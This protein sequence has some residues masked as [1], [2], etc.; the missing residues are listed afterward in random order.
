MGW[1]D[2]RQTIL[3]ACTVCDESEERAVD[4]DIVLPDYYAPIA[5]IVKCTLHPVVT[6]CGNVGGRYTVD[7]IAKLRMLYVSDDRQHLYCYE[8]NHPFSVAFCADDAVHHDIDIYVDY[9]NCRASAPRRADVHAAFRVHMKAVGTYG[10]EMFAPPQVHDVFCRTTTLERSIP[11][12]EIYKSFSVEDAIELGVNVD[13]MIYTDIEMSSYECKPLLNKAI[14]KGVLSVRSMC[15]INDHN[16]I[17][18]QEIPFSQIIDVN[19]LC[20]DWQCEICV[21]VGEN[22]CHLQQGETGGA[23]L[24]INARL[25]ACARCTAVLTDEIVLDAYAVKEAVVCELTPLHTITMTPHTPVKV[26]C[27]QQTNAPENTADIL[28]VKGVV[29]TKDIV[30]KNGGNTLLC[31]V[32]VSMIVRDRDGVLHHCERTVDL[33]C[34]LEMLC[35]DATVRCVRVSPTLN[36]EQVRLQLELLITPRMQSETV[37]DAV[38]AVV[39]DDNAPIFRSPA[40]IRI[41]YAERGES[42]WD[43]AKNHHASVDEIVAENDVHDEVL[44]SPTMLMI[45][46]V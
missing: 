19:G 22:E 4:L 42:L 37:V 40:A 44:L 41:V 33:E 38:S 7:G 3:T 12:Q 21:S 30:S 13:K 17:I 5:A 9:V 34:V 35:S 6:S 46:M 43:I 32:L 27:H 10:A 23:L 39:V 29:R 16:T 24:M 2:T 26:T 18:T 20:E 28:D 31:C 8:H 45:P 36:G 11:T 25:L 15:L 1:K 14:I